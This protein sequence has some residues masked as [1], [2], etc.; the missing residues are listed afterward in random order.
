MLIVRPLPRGVSVAVPCSPEPCIGKSLI[1]IAGGPEAAITPASMSPMA[2]VRPSFTSPVYHVVGRDPTLEH[3]ANVRVQGPVGPPT[4]QAD[5]AHEN[6][7]CCFSLADRSIIVKVSNALRFALG[8]TAI[9]ILVAGCS[10]GASS[11]ATPSGTAMQ[12]TAGHAMAGSPSKQIKP[13]VAPGWT[14]YDYNPSGHALFPQPANYSGGVASFSFAPN[15]FTALLTTGD[16]SLTGDLT[17]KTLTDTIA[18]SGATDI[19][20]TQNGGGCGNPPAVRFYFD[21]PGFAYTNFWW[22]NPVSYVLANGT[23]TLTAPLSDP[24]QWSD[25]NGQLGTQNPGE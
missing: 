22:S 5:A 11:P 10:A 2:I 19:F 6:E 3:R 14:V 21:T 24:T 8:A 7:A 4:N 18:V 17:G 13:L 9:G 23:V 20:V 25:W 16:K 1:S 12:R 15:L